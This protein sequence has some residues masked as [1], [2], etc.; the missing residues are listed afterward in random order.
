MTR[1]HGEFG[2]RRIGTRFWRAPAYGAVAMAIALSTVALG[3]TPGAAAPSVPKSAVS[4]ALQ[5]TGGTAG[6]ANPKKSPISIGWVSDETAITGHPGNTAGVKAAVALINKNLGGIDGH[7]VK[8]VSC[9]I[10]TSDSQGAS[11][12]EQMLNNSSVKVVAE[13]ELLT[14]EASFIG[15]MAGQKPV[16]GVFTQPSV[17]TQNAYYLDGGIPSQLASVTYIAKSLKAK[18]VAVIGPN[19]PGVSSALAMF[20]M[21]FQ[22]LGVNSTV[23]EYPSSSTDVE[24][25]IAAANAQSSDAIFLATSTTG[26]CIAVAKAFQELGIT[27]PVVSLSDCTE[28]AVKSSLGDYPKWYYVFTSPNP[29]A[30]HSATSQTA[31]FDAAMAAYSNPKLVNS[32]FAPLT[33]GTILTIAKWIKQLGVNFT[34]ADIAKTAAAF[35]GPMFLGDPNI[36]FGVPP[37]TAIGSIR[38]LFYQLQGKGQVRRDDGWAVDLPASSDLHVV[39]SARRPARR[40]RAAAARTHPGL[41]GSTR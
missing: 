38:A 37:F 9:F 30:A 3:A 32:G 23:V 19:L 36:K 17:T 12:A 21:L 8:L 6:A 4:A 15:T 20:K 25:A 26:E 11:C 41:A 27:K 24:T 22:V 35:T 33:F 34:S 31:T 40:G 29:L 18:N 13:G 10:T 14:G 5:Y 7:P 2:S 28:Q 39:A 16:I 1:G